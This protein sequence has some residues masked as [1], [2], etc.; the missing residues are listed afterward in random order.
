VLFEK[1]VTHWFYW[2]SRLKR[3]AAVIIA[4][5]IADDLQDVMG[6]VYSR[7]LFGNDQ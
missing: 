7:D 1:A 3:E 4:N 5:R 6:K 2:L